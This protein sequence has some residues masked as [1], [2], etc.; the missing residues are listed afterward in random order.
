MGTL[1]H[2]EGDGEV[3]DRRSIAV[4]G[5]GNTADPPQLR[6]GADA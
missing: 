6:A 2:A 3:A 4:V 1:A 5:V